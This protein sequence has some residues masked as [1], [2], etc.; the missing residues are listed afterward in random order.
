MLK[1]LKSQVTIE[2]FE[3]LYDDHK[4]QVAQH[5]AEQELFGEILDEDELLGELDALAAGD[6]LENED[7]IPDAPTGAIAAAAPR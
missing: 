6:V 4:D 2:Q 5:E 1:E 3:E 7:A